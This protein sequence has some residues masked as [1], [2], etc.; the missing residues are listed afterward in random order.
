M[1]NGE[2]PDWEELEKLATGAC[3]PFTVEMKN[4]RGTKIPVIGKRL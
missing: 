4:S 3:C 1:V 2:Q